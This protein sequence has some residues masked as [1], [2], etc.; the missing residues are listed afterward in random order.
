MPIISS[1]ILEN[2]PQSDGRRS[3]RERHTADDGTNYDACYLA[4]PGTDVNAVMV[5]R[6][7]ILDQMLADAASAAN[8][9]AAR[10]AAA[11]AAV[12]QANY[13]LTL[14]DADLTAM[15]APGVNLA[16]A[17]ANA[18]VIVANGGQL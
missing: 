17:R 3:V 2:Q 4:E 1:I 16:T 15:L 7:P 8:E 9:Q 11:Q 10:V 12:L 5:A 18:A 6:V 13:M 14:D